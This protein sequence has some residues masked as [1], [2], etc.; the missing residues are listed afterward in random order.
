MEKWKNELLLISK[1]RIVNGEQ[2]VAIA[3]DGSG[4]LTV[5]YESFEF[6]RILLHLSFP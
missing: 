1:Q 4:D 3:A 6:L 2:R 5:Y